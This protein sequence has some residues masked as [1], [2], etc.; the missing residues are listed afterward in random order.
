M[1]TI[2]V[3]AMGGD[4][5]PRAEVEGAL[6]AA[7]Y[8]GVRVVLVGREDLIRR[9]LDQHEHEGL[10]VEVVHASEQVTMEDSAAKAVRSKRDSS[11]RVASRLVRDGT[12]Q[13][14]VSGGNT[15]AVMAT[16]KMVQGVVPG[17]ERPA[18]LGIFPTMLGTPVVL[19]DVGANVDCS[20]EM[21]AQFA[22]MG[23][24]YSRNILHRPN[25]RVGILSIGEEEHKG[26]DLTRAA[27]PL[28]K[29]LHI[30]FIGNVEGRDVYAGNVDVIVCDGFTGNVALKVSEGLVD[31]F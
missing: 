3:D 11:L 7:R 19:V 2:A 21:L 27:W 23:E 8:L 16:A 17:V 12:A 6:Q 14:F 31:M 13:G 24:I 30:N 28:L 9:E 20:P 10:P 26:N 4:H 1:V 22:I 18:L 15:G 29:S 5:A 25:P